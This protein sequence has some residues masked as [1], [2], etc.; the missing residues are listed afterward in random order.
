MNDDDSTMA[1]IAMLQSHLL[2]AQIGA[3]D[4]LYLGS[5]AK[6]GE[7]ADRTSRSKT[8]PITELRA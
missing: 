4:E 8:V 5:G 6:A 2:V 1:I 7:I 3:A